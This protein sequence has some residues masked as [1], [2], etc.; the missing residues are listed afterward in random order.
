MGKRRPQQSFADIVREVEAAPEP[1]KP[2][3]HAGL[4]PDE[5]VDKDNRHYVL[6][7]EDVSEERALEAAR[8]GALV[9]W[10]TC[11]CGGYCGMEWFT[12]DDVQRMVASGRPN[13]SR[14]KRRRGSVSEWH[15]EDGTVLLLA[16][17]A[18]AWGD[19]MT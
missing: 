6:V 5:F 18:V 1:P 11:G 2:E 13:I 15:A 4:Y 10:D 14:T 3:R 17:D 7:T 12:A 19:V 9:V 8:T 16:E